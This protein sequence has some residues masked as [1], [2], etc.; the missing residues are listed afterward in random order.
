[1]EYKW[2]D[3]TEIEIEN[4]GKSPF[5]SIQTINSLYISN[6]AVR[7]FK[8]PT[9][10]DVFI[11]FANGLGLDKELINDWYFVAN[12]KGKG[13]KAT[14]DKRKQNPGIRL[15]NQPF[16]TMLL[17]KIKAKVGESFYLQKTGNELDGFPIIQ[18]LTHKSINQ[19]K[20]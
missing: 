9:D 15:T 19:L 12:K 20:K 14:I 8:I 10:E 1:M 17:R 4:K 13:F 6:S 16:V 18:I 3:K 7:L 2:L 11:N 5:I